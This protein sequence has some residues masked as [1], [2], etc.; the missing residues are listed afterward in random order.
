MKKCLQILFISLFC[1]FSFR[2][3]AQELFLS[4]EVETSLSLLPKDKKAVFYNIIGTKNNFLQP[5]LE[6]D[7]PEGW[8]LLTATNID[9]LLIGEH[10]EPFFSFQVSDRAKAG[11]H[12]ILIK[13]KENGIPVET[14]KVNIEIKEVRNIEVIALEKPAFVEEKAAETIKFLV[15]NIGNT[16]EKINLASSGKIL[17]DN[18]FTLL[19]GQSRQVEVTYTLPLN[20]GSIERVSFDIDA[21]LKGDLK[22]HGFTFSVPYL[23]YNTKK[24]DPFHRFPVDIGLLFNGLSTGS[25][26]AGAWQFDING[27]GYL[28]LNKKHEL[29][30]IARGPDRFNLPRFGNIDQYFV[31]Y[32][33]KYGKI[34]LGDNNF[35]ISQLIEANRYA[36]GIELSKEI[37]KWKITAFRAIPRFFDDILNETGGTISLKQSEEAM[38]K[39]NVMRKNHLYQG[40]QKQTDFISTSA[41]LNKKKFQ[42]ETELSLSATDKKINAGVFNNFFL[43]LDRF[44]L[45][46]NLVYT[47]KEYFGY[48][49]NSVFVNNNANYKITPKFSFVFFQ[50]YSQINPS[51]DTFYYLVA[52]YT[53]NNGVE[54]AYKF[55]KRHNFRVNYNQGGREDRMEEKKFDFKEKLVRYFYTA[56]FSKLSLRFE[57]DIGQVENLLEPEDTRRSRSQ[58][59]N[60]FNL[61]YT[62]VRNINFGGFA[63]YLN[64]SRFSTIT[65]QS[66]FLFYGFQSSV[67]FKNNFDMSLF[68]RNNYAPDEFFQSQSFFD[69]SASYRV[70][71]H[72]I[73]LVSSHS[74]LPQQGAENTV[75][76]SLRYTLHLNAP[77]QKK[78]NLGHVNGFISG[79]KKSGIMLNLNGEKVMTDSTG[80]FKFNDLVPGRYLLNVEK[81]SLGFGNIVSGNKALFVDVQ[82]DSTRDFKIEVVKTGKIQGKVIA[83]DKEEDVTNTIPNMIIEVYNDHFSQLTSTNKFGEF[84]F[85]EL[86]EGDYMLRIRSEE[87]TKAYKIENSNN[88]VIVKKGEES[89]F[90]FLLEPKKRKVQFQKETI[91][92]SDTKNK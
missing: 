24:S 54:L 30:F 50:N 33:N 22:S 52:P 46:S 31:S 32:K 84:N 70:K 20:V 14:F 89:M 86:E 26:L 17:N 23:S 12:T 87:M 4:N 5:D 28:D 37:G 9:R 40:Q 35:N 27:E 78:K 75:F 6:I 44:K 65:D 2:T 81:S 82:P 63:E 69:F 36:R 29:T 61:L 10:K 51:L 49:N 34:A 90:T 41:Q 11:N 85:S 68:Y 62:P 25:D 38:F 57:G 71:Q 21:F 67:R 88:K 77:L 58:I 66:E 73:S 19:A 18:D 72:E 3:I 79:V 15:R 80:S 91:I 56:D 53:H 64:T 55:S 39:L 42:L 74:F 7:L 60:R 13:L 16:E 59:R 45:S 92:L 47:S 83:Y 76:V 1:C 43:N 48:Y 8:Q